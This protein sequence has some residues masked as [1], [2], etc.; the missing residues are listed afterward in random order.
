MAELESPPLHRDAK[1]AIS[2]R[3]G[4]SKAFGNDASAAIA[5]HKFLYKV[6]ENKTLVK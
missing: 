2:L 3:K 5:E 6:S 4:G 1:V